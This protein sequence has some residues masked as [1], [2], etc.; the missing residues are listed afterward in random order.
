[1]FGLPMGMRGNGDNVL[2]ESVLV[3][4]LEGVVR[5]QRTILSDVLGVDEAGLEK[6]PQ[7]WC[8]YKDVSTSCKSLLVFILRYM[9]RGC[10]PGT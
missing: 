6:V 9:T 2:S 8:L 4:L 5:D 3:D 7:V 10:I 1:M